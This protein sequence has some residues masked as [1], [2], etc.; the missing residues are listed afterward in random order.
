[1]RRALVLVAA[2]ACT[3]VPPEPSPGVAPVPALEPEAPMSRE[4]RPKELYIRMGDDIVAAPASDLAVARG[5]DASRDKGEVVDGL[6]LTLLSAERRVSVGED[7]RV[8]HV[9]EA[10]TRI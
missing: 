10:V 8:I 7:V 3:A 2:S 1:M 9:V 4:P 6:R 5:Y